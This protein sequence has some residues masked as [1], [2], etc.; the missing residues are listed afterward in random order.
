[1]ELFAR[2]E[3]NPI[4]SP[5][6]EHTWESRAT[7]N[8]AVIQHEGVV[9]M[10]YRAIGGDANYVSRLGLARSEDGV[11]FERS[12]TPWLAPSTP[13]DRWGTEDPRM[14]SIDGTIY[15]T[16]TAISQ[17]VF[18]SKDALRTDPLIAQV[19]LI[20]TRD[21][22]YYSHQGLITPDLSDNKD[23]VLFPEKINDCFVMLHRPHRWSKEWFR[24]AQW[25]EKTAA[26]IHP[27]DLPE[28]PSIWIS[29][30]KDL[31]SW[32]DHAVVIEPTHETDEKV[33]AGAPPI[34][35]EHGWLLVYH[36]VVK[37][38]EEKRTYAAKVAL[39]DLEDPSSVTA[40][41]TDHVLEPRA[42]Y[43]TTGDVA[44]VVFPTGAIVR[45]EVL[46]MYYGAADT[47]CAL[48][49]AP[50]E[51]ILLELTGNA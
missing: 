31:V 33:G 16:Y 29:Y 12:D 27:D 10:L 11:H 36:H 39:L 20:S 46:Y 22:S 34:K 15:I 23:T 6:P 28:K 40:K 45:D 42:A 5:D 9:Y 50:L 13:N 38:S 37:K 48:A 25:D 19:N 21:F 14:V 24:S 18:E 7:F 51:R 44:D 26:P 41:I 32:F 8:P 3:Y 1:M 2:S 47:H 30:S 49:T 17:P 4:L 43:E 35:T